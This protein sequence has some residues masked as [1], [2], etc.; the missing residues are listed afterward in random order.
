MIAERP[1]EEKQLYIP[2]D[3]DFIHIYRS[4]MEKEDPSISVSKMGKD[5]LL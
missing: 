2:N 3:A 1:S 5:I 4:E